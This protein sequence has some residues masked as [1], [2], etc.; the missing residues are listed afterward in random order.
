MYLQF[1][2]L[3]TISAFHQQHW[4]LRK[5][6]GLSSAGKAA[7]FYAAQVSNIPAVF[8]AEPDDLVSLSGL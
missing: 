6:A 2:L 3:D 1:Q 4:S 5:R 8:M 7:L